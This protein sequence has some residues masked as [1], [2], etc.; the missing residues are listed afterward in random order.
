MAALVD[1]FR[2]GRMARPARGRSDL[3]TLLAQRCPNLVDRS[4]WGLIDAAERANG[5]A[6]NRPRVKFTRTEHMVATARQG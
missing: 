2:A 3:S 6:A 5:A 1:D 4:G